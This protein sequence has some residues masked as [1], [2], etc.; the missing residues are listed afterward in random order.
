MDGSEIRRYKI[1]KER[2]GSDKKI[3]PSFFS[4]FFRKRISIPTIY[5]RTKKKRNKRKGFN[6]IFR[7]QK[8]KIRKR[9]ISLWGRGENITHSPKKTLLREC[10]Q[11]KEKS[12][13]FF[14]HLS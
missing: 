3:V 9:W 5:R 7:E 14:I 1:K 6:K 8:K 4:Y 12:S 2:N 10:K 11:L 13:N